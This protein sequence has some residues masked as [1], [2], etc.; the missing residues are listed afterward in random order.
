MERLP[1]IEWRIRRIPSYGARARH[2]EVVGLD[3]ADG[4]EIGW[5]WEDGHRVDG[6]RIAAHNRRLSWRHS[7][8]REGIYRLG[9]ADG[10]ASAAG[11]AY[12]PV[13][14]SGRELTAAGL[15]LGASN[16][17]AIV[18]YGLLVPG[19]AALDDEVSRGRL[20]CDLPGRGPLTGQ[21]AWVATS[22]DG[23]WH[24]GGLLSQPG[25]I[26]RAFRLHLWPGGRADGQHRVGRGELRVYRPAGVP[27]SDAPER[28]VTGLMVG[29]LDDG[30]PPGDR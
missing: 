30:L 28:A 5:W 27:G 9:L 8:E 19:A 24:I 10:P 25:H 16:P 18:R 23:W 7:F 17:A 1:P 29:W 11:T 6:Q 20:R 22:A 4:D 26:D 12:V 15:I 2:L 3:V 14:S 13:G 21:V